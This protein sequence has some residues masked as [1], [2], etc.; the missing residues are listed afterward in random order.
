M[1]GRSESVVVVGAGIIGLA[2]G[3]YLRDAGYE[4]TLVDRESAGGAC[5]H[6]NMGLVCPSHILP[7]TE[8]STLQKGLKSLLRPRS[9]FRIRPQLRV[10]LYEWL[11]QFARRCRYPQMIEA[12]THLR[13]IL[14]SSIAEYRRL[15]AEH[16]KLA[17]EWR[18][19]GLLYVFER[20]QGLD[21]FAETD[22]IVSREFGVSA[23]RL[24]GSAL[25]AMEPALR[26]GLA[27]AYYYPED[28]SIRP[29]TLCGA[30][31]AHLRS[32]GVQVLEN[33][34]I[35]G[36][37]KTGHRIDALITES[38]SISADHYV[39]AA[40]AWSRGIGR[41]LGKKLP[42][43][44]G[45]GY[46]MTLTVA[47]GLT[48]RPLLLPERHVG[49][50][51]F[52]GGLRIGSMMEFVGYD[53]TIPELRIRQLSAAATAV[54]RTEPE[55][56]EEERWYGWR[57][58]TW[59]SLPIIGRLQELDNAIVATGHNMIGLAL[60]PATGKLVAEIIAE[61]PTHI[62]ADAFNPGR[63]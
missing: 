59:D 49:I 38:E 12:G 50:T 10:E 7:L 3:H 16:P 57:P 41:L 23:R 9:A 21:A 45:K 43:E 5:S 31:S 25:S 14:D 2:C 48:N 35:T 28:A 17:E 26:E 22:E 39:F 36:I 44:P 18:D 11:W 58:M 24:D 63:F 37:R 30:W 56:Q 52:R 42:V 8:P 15:V 29:D 62:P 61:R 4:V 54:L 53:R 27:G 13:A 20:E 55:G 51:P 1:S 32:S 33:R 6:G 34:E 46:S 19:E 40:G 47:H 60:A